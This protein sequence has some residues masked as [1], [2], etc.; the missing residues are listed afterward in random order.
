MFGKI[1]KQIEKLFGEVKMLNKQSLAHDNKIE[2]IERDIA[3]LKDRME[4]DARLL[5]CHDCDKYPAVD[6]FTRAFCHICE[7]GGFKLKLVDYPNTQKKTCLD[8]MD[9]FKK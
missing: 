3:W 2:H 8:D 1:K 9:L 6:E 4:E 5:H 7:R